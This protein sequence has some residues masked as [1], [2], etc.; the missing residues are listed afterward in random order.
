MV[1]NKKL[2]DAIQRYARS[3]HLYAWSLHLNAWSLHLNAW[4]LH[5]NAWLL[6]L[7]LQKTIFSKKTVNYLQTGTWSSSSNV[8]ALKYSA[9][10]SESTPRIMQRE[11][12]SP[13]LQHSLHNR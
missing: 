7:L 6:H 9:E 2:F 8:N 4:S 3:L 1:C 12:F 5:H 13:T 10:Y 11:F